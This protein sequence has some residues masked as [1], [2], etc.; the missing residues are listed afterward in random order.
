MPRDIASCMENATSKLRTIYFSTQDVAFSIYG[1]VKY[2]EEV[3]SD[4]EPINQANAAV[5]YGTYLKEQ[6]EK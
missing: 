6:K 5:F 3:A 1:F 2:G 4:L